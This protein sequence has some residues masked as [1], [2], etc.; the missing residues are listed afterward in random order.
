MVEEAW[1]RVCKSLQNAE[2]VGVVTVEDAKTSVQKFQEATPGA[3]NCGIM[4]SLV[5]GN[6]LGI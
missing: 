1:K 3:W 2:A 5:E 4:G 6:Q